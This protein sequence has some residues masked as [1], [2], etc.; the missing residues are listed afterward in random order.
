MLKKLSTNLM[1]INIFE[2]INFYK[3][4]LGFEFVMAV[5][6][7]FNNTVFELKDITEKTS[8]VYAM[9]KN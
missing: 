9:M 7:D 3:D 1:V 4:I 2:T 8:L 6:G 5:Q